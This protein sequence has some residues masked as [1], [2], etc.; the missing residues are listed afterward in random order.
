MLINTPINIHSCPLESGGRSS[1][2]NISIND[3]LR[4]RRCGLQPL[5]QSVSANPSPLHLYS[6]GRNVIML[7]ANI[8]TC[9]S[10]L[11]LQVSTFDQG[12]CCLSAG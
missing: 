12:C 6:A 11:R 5:K 7:A 4:P 2:S 9:S 8:C 10:L 3:I 1:I